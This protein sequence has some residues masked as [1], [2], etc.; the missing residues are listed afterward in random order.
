MVTEDP[1]QEKYLTTGGMV[2]RFVLSYIASAGGA[3]SVTGLS[4]MEQNC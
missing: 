2:K 1:S 3:G 4:P